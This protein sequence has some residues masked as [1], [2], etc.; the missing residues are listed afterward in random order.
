[1]G[2]QRALLAP[3]EAH[4]MREAHH[5]ELPEP[6]VELSE[7]GGQ[8]VIDVGG[9]A[10]GLVYLPLMQP[11]GPDDG[12]FIQAMLALGMLVHEMRPLVDL[13]VGISPWGQAMEQDYLEAAK[14]HLD[15]LLGAGPGAAMPGRFEKEGR[16]LYLRPHDK[17]K[18]L[19]VIRLTGHPLFDQAYGLG[20]DKRGLVAANY[21]PLTDS[22]PTDPAVLDILR[23]D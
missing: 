13:V 14:P 8:E 20:V 12:A 15:I 21:I 1:M 3:T 5:G 9:Q 11:A 23:G 2:Y 4:A 19:A 10:I 22:I 16:T 6:F 18:T 17:G 7:Q